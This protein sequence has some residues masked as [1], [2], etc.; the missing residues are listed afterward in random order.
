MSKYSFTFCIIEDSKLLG[1]IQYLNDVS[2]EH[3]MDNVSKIFNPDLP[4]DNSHNKLNQIYDFVDEPG[5]I[6]F[7]E[8]ELTIPLHTNIYVKVDIG[9]K[10]LSLTSF[11]LKLYR[12]VNSVPSDSYIK[13]NDIENISLEEFSLINKNRDTLYIV[14][15]HGDVYLLLSN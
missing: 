3:V 6:A 7:D 2:F 1:Y 13:V 8:S 11:V 14:D 12:D 10:T 4:L 5:V 9:L 15:K